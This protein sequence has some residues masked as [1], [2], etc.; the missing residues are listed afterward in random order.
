MA[1]ETQKR[2]ERQKHMENL[3]KLNVLEKHTRIETTTSRLQEGR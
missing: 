3:R 2:L 1:E